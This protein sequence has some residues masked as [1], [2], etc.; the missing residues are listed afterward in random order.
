[1][2]LEYQGD[3]EIA[4]ITHLESRQYLNHM[5]NEYQP[6]RLTGNN[7]IPLSPKTVRNIWVTDGDLD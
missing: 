6:R 3:T 4:R 7:D 2:W 1:M 5:L